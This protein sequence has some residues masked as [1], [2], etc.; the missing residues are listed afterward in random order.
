MP[1]IAAPAL[2]SF[3]TTANASPTK[4]SKVMEHLLEDLEQA[5]NCCPSG[6]GDYKMS[7]QI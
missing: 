6:P 4:F 3:D 1:R 2:T 7:M 5:E